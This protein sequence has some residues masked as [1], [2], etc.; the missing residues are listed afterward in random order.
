MLLMESVVKIRHAIL[1][2]KESIRSVSR[3]TGLSR[4]TIRKY[5][6]DPSPTSYQRS[7]FSVLH[8]LSSFEPRLRDLYEHAHESIV[9]CEMV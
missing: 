6:Q 9:A 8:K 3:R 2:N 5:L 1:R 7:V 4:I